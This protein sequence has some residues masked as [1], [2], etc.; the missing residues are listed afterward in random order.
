VI[1]FLGGHGNGCCDRCVLMP[2]EM[3][4]NDWATGHGSR[5]RGPPGSFHLQPSH[6]PRISV[7]REGTPVNSVCKDSSTKDVIFSR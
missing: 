3:F 2:A 6:V 7:H 4:R 1:G 5:V